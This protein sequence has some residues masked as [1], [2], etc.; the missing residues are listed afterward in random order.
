MA[1][2]LDPESR[3]DGLPVS[4]H[5]AVTVLGNLLDNAIEAVT[6]QPDARVSVLIDAGSTHLDLRVEDSG[7]GVPPEA[8]DQVF[9]RGWSTKGLTLE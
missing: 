5:D 2:E 1:L 8:R 9:E 7:P 3:V 6:G 4:A